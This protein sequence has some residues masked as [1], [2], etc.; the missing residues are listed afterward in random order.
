MLG[1][2]AFEMGD[3]ASYIASV[4]R[5][6]AD[7]RN[8][9]ASGRP[10]A[11][12]VAAC[13]LMVRALRGGGKVLL[14]GNGG[15][16]ADAQH[17]A[18]ELVGRLTVDRTPLPAIALTV[19]TSAL[20]AIAN[21]FGFAHVFERQLRALGKPGDVAVAITTS[22]KSE[23]IL[24]AVTVAKEM[25]IATIGLTG[26]GGGHFASACDVGVVVPSTDTARVQECHITVGHL[27]CAVAEAELCGVELQR[28]PRGASKRTT[29]DELLPVRADMR[30]RG[31]TVVWTN[32]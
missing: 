1:Y 2:C 31:R 25:G 19:D 29:L 9:M 4:L 18:A 3:Y 16:A 8:D 15:S 22:G 13:D 7:L 23:S 20:T 14:F 17:I 28:A 5:E 11:S 21:D 32:G 10:H 6:G 30:A 27:L 24:R 12:I 26:A